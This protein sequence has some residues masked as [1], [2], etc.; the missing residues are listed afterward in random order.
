[1][2]SIES[3]SPNIL[4]GAHTA[5]CGSQLRSDDPGSLK[6]ITNLVKENIKGREV[7]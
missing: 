1:M 2:R 4:G 5:G 7:K 6:D 3:F